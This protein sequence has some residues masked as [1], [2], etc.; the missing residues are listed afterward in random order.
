M[1]VLKEDFRVPT[2][3]VTHDVLEA[4]SLADRVLI[5]SGGRVIQSGLPAEVFNNPVNEEVVSMTDLSK[6]Y[7]GYLFT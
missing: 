6:L 1:S 7:P 3:L 2:V 5:Y 4:Y